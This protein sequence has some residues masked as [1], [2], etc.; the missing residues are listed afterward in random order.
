MH[1]GH[2]THASR[3]MY[4]SLALPTVHAAGMVRRT[5]YLIRR[6]FLHFEHSPITAFPI[7]GY[8]EC[9]AMGIEPT[10]LLTRRA[11]HYRY[12]LDRWLRTSVVAHFSN[13]SH[14]SASSQ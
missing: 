6:A 4:S 5:L 10:Q 1:L 3:S 14:A 13:S 12:Y 11:N 8:Y 7:G 2:G 9:P